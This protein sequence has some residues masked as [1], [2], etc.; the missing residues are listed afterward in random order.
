M[1]PAF[2]ALLV[3]EMKG[4]LYTLS[5]EGYNAIS[6][7][8]AETF[9]KAFGLSPERMPLDV[10]ALV[11]FYLAFLVLVFVLLRLSLSERYRRATGAVSRG[12]TRLRVAVMR[13][14]GVRT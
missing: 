6:G 4:Q 8:K 5:V 9:I 12:V 3:N 14:M 1:A 13:G 11:L 10:L 2:E 7:V